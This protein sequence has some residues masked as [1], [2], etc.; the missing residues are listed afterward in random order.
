[1]TTADKRI[2]LSPP[3]MSGEELRLVK[4]VFD[5]NWIAP[6][7]PDLESF[8]REFCEVIGCANAIALSSGTAALH[9]AM[10]LTGVGPG[11]EVLCSDFTFAAS[12]NTIVYTGAKPVFIDCDAKTWNI[13][14]ELLDEVLEEKNLAGKPPKAVLVVHL[15]GQCADIAPIVESCNRFGVDLIEDS[16]E[17]LGAT[18]KD[19]F[20][21]TFG[22]LGIFSFNGNK[23]ITTSGGGMLVSDDKELVERARVL[24]TQA[25][26]PAPHYEH[27]QIGYNYR[28]SNVLAAI[29]RGQLR[30]LQQRVEAKRR[31]FEYYNRMLGDLPGIEFMPELVVG[32][33]TRWLTCITIDPDIFGTDRET[34]RLALEEKN[35][36]S[37]PVWKPMHMQPVFADAQVIGGSVSEGLFEKG[38]CLP[39][40]TGM[41]K[42]DL[43]RVV[44]IVRECCTRKM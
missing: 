21:G 28:L 37:R 20:T 34:V 8:E 29:G 38:L 12:A 17:A 2:Y 31:I 6:A 14:P 43:Q 13:D 30:A 7:G 26:D 1:M 19:R 24:A 40:G 15:Y 4:A 25:R 23:I 41:T 5:S 9:L 32:R 39:S 18:Y 42:G 16:A 35:V 11:D 36:E 3:H 10:I 44:N 33:G 27:S 22:R